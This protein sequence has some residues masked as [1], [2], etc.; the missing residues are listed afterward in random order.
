MATTEPLTENSRQGINFKIP[1]CNGP[2]AWLSPNPRPGCG[3]AYDETPVGLV[4]YV[5]N[6]PVNL[7]DPDGRSFFRAIGGFFG[8]VGRAV[9]TS[10]IAA[11][12]FYVGSWRDHE[13]DPVSDDPLDADADGPR[14]PSDY[15]P[16]GDDS[17]GD[18]LKWLDCLN[19]IV[20]IFDASLSNYMP[21]ANNAADFTSATFAVITDYKNGTLNSDTAFATIWNLALGLAG[22]TAT[23]ISALSAGFGGYLA[24]VGGLLT[25]LTAT[26]T[27][28]LEL[29]SLEVQIP[30][31]TQ[32]FAADWSQIRDQPNTG[33]TVGFVL[34]KF[35]SGYGDPNLAAK[36]ANDCGVVTGRQ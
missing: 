5:R 12:D 14:G 31:S 36:I 20:A 10:V 29:A 8:K 11:V 25:F 28:G 35:L 9:G 2:R 7:V 16:G 4:V 33:A 32:P 24:P 6:D 34:A 15:G 13:T 30:K 17:D 1:P 21:I 19:D 18:R 26:A 22:G 27:S 3:H 23:N